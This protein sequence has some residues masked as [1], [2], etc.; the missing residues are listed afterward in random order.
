MLK[1]LTVLTLI[2]VLA[3]AA[4]P[5]ASAQDDMMTIESV[6]L[7]T[8]VGR[9][10]DGTF[11]QYAFEGMS[12]AVEDFE[13]DSTYIETTSPTDYETNIG[14]CLSEGYDAIVTVGFLLAD[15]TLAAA[16]ENPDTYFIGI[17]QF[18]VDGPENFVGIQFREDQG[19]FLVGALA[20][21]VSESGVVAGV[22]G[23]EIPPVVKFRSGYEQGVAFI[24]AVTGSEVETLGAYIDSF[25]APDRGA[26]T[27]NQ[28]IGDGADVIF[29]A[30]GQTGSGGISAA[31]AEGIYVIGVDQDEWFTTFG[32][33]ESPGSDLIISSAVKRVDVGVY[34]MLGALT[35]DVDVEFPGGG[36]YILDVAN[37]GITFAEKHEADVD[38]AIYE[39][40]AEIEAA[41]ADGT[42]DTGVDPVGGEVETAIEDMEMEF[43]F[44]E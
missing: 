4:L 23:A 6:C 14:T 30:G 10:N 40:I 24:N 8:D 44:S 35:G 19:G 37:G 28:F 15:D 29:G 25:E 5:M 21:L 3:I 27:A 41:L 36:L 32:E 43:E 26:S 33:G 20:A 2:V 18:V 7:I 16:A 39:Q 38:D 34:D 22:Y 1:K 9:I 12:A 17:D 11:N 31:A 13:L 42:I